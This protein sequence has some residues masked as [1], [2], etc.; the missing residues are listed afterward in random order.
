MT[1]Q[2]IE[3]IIGETK[4]TLQSQ[5]GLMVKEDPFSFALTPETIRLIIKATIQE[6]E[7]HQ[8]RESKF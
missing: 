2:E 7:S 4:D 1:P 6:V 5:Y 3:S 8:K